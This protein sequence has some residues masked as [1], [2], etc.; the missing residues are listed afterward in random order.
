MNLSSTTLRLV[1]LAA[2]SSMAA[3]RICDPMLVPL[4]R[5]FGITTGDAA[6]VVSAYAIAYGLL[7]LFYGPLGDRLGKVKVV[8]GGALACGL[9]SALTAAAPSFGLLVLAR[10]AMGA[11]AAGIIPL[12]MAWIGDQVPYEQRQETLAKLLGATVSGMMV[13]QWFGGFAADV[14]H[15]RWAFVVLALL[16][17]TAGTLLWRETARLP[18]A[19][20]PASGQA[21]ISLGQQALKTLQLL[22]LPR[23]RWVLGVTGLE[24]ALAFGPLAFAPSQLVERF[25]L[26][27]STAASVMV[28]YG[29]GGLLYSQFA[30]RWLG[31]LGEKGLARLGGSLI[32]T[33]LLGFAWGTQAWQGV[34]G[35]LVAGLGFYMLHNTLQTQATQM[36]PEARGTAVTL[37]AGILFLGQSL[38]VTA[39][40]TG[41]RWLSTS[42]LFTGAAL[43]VL[44]LCLVI[45]A[46]VQARAAP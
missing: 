41:G 29:I 17:L 34:L 31:L 37:F 8:V 15:W 11:A 38:G 39:V 19:P 35:S 28:L 44:A 6:A 36:A 23:V 25:G 24:G 2:F 21:T 45:S 10:T 9:L 20:A 30:R 3:T 33:G 43:G 5:E 18:K 1:G 7:Q 46:R 22:R 14:L 13:G 27:V 12:S 32:A 42:L 40:A 16:F 26:S 4:S